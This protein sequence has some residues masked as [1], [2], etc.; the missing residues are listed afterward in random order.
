M[1]KSLVSY[2]LYT[3]RS[4]LPSVSPL[5]ENRQIKIKNE[6]SHA[7]LKFFWQMK[8]VGKRQM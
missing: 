8:A 5:P 7:K 1:V 4:T 6:L 2:F 3:L